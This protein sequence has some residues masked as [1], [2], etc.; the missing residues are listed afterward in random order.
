MARLEYPAQ[1]AKERNI[2]PIQW[3]VLCDLVFAG[4]KDAQMILKAFDYATVRNYD[5]FLGHVAIVSQ[6][7]KGEKGYE[8]FEAVWP[9]LKALVYSAHKTGEFAGM[10]PMVYGDIIPFGFGDREQKSVMAPEYVTCTVYR[11]VNGARCAFTETVFFEEFVSLRN[12]MPTFIWAS[13]PRLMIAKCAKAAALR[14]GFAEC[15]YSAEE[16]EGKIVDFDGA[17]RNSPDERTANAGQQGTPRRSEPDL[18]TTAYTRDL[19]DE[20]QRN[21]DEPQAQAGFRDLNRDALDWFAQH[22]EVTVQN[23]AFGS[24]IDY[25]RQEIPRGDFALCKQLL[26]AAE[27]V[28]MSSAGNEI[29]AMLKRCASDAPSQGS[30]VFVWLRGQVHDRADRGQLSDQD[31]ASI[32]VIIDF[33]E[34]YFATETTRHAA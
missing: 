26:E 17:A 9:T 32:D 5:P 2:D 20:D 24:A 27:T 34:A 6:S 31:V 4:T 22:L 12:G 13:K 3:G 10:E 28:A 25:A 11:I 33:Y 23:R 8:Y 16:M 19:S 18:Q 1:Q 21:Q 14:L 29:F 30:R 15:D 7:R